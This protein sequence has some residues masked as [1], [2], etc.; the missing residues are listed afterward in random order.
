MV[1]DGFSIFVISKGKSAFCSLMLL[2]KMK[3][4]FSLAQ[5][6]VGDW[7]FRIFPLYELMY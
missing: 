2:F 1:L 7:S 3:F 6:S 4:S 5:T